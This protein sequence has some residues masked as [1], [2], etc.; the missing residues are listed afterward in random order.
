MDI[1]NDFY[2]ELRNVIK[3]P[4]ICKKNKIKKITEQSLD[5][6]IESEYKLYLDKLYSYIASIESED[7]IGFFSASCKDKD[8][9][10]YVYYILT[11]GLV[12]YDVSTKRESLVHTLLSYQKEDG[13][14]YD[15]N[16]ISYKF[17]NGDGWG[18]RHFIPHYLIAM[19][20]LQEKLR[21]RLRYTDAF[22]VPG[23]I[24]KSLESLDWTN[25]WAASNFILNIGVA[26]LY[27][28]NNNNNYSTVVRELQKWLL[29]NIRSDSGMWGTGNI[30]TKYFRYLMVRGAY[31]I[32]PILLY[33]NIDIP[34]HKKA[35]DIIL[36]LQNSVGGFDFEWRS[37]ACD[38]IDA[39]EPLIRLALIDPEYRQ[40]EVKHT[41]EKAF[42][43]LI[44]N[45]REDGGNV[46]RLGES[47]CYGGS[48]MCSK[49]NE[50]NW[51][52]TW[53]RTLAICYI[54]DYL[55]GNKRNY[56]NIPGMEYPLFR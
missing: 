12:E 2:Y 32:Y 29:D 9:Y 10:S 40:I 1:K 6:N 38:D 31:H 44:F 27:E 36:G 30:K 53:F 3:N 33:D 43:W 23:T 5:E 42:R 51:F 49:K 7:R 18:A 50:S 15:T 37:S 34:Y 22:I 25:P 39:I 41:L 24:T 21:F 8:M 45:Q 47:F 48:I 52:G 46:F 35:I 4:D 19:E 17:I 26:L 14:C 55:T 20:R 56:V 16:L 13:L 11:T 54:Y 28:R